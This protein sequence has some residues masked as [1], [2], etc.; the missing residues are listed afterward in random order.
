MEKKV[1]EIIEELIE[2]VEELQEFQDG[3]EDTI[4]RAKEVLKQI[5]N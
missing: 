2:G 3:W 5:K 4:K 1:I